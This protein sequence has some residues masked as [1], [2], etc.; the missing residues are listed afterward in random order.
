MVID[1][2]TTTTTTTPTQSQVDR[3]Q[4][5]SYCERHDL[6]D[7]SMCYA[8]TIYDIEVR[9]IT[10]KLA[11][12]YGWRAQ[13]ALL[14]NSWRVKKLSVI[15]AKVNVTDSAGY[16]LHHFHIMLTDIYFEFQI[17]KDCHKFREGKV[18]WWDQ[19]KYELITELKRQ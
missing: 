1:E 8:S 6:V 19:S 17:C 10:L 5:Y 9:V 13:S 15:Y 7:H 4:D 11:A 18:K 3:S 12:I 2:N 14:F 16:K